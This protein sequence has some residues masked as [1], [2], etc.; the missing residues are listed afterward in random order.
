MLRRGRHRQDPP[1]LLGGRVLDHDVEH[2]A[3]ELRLGQRI[4]AFLL[5][6][7]LRRE[8]EQRPLE[9]VADAG[10]RDLVLLHRLE[11]RRL[12]LGRR[13]VDLVRQDDVREDRAV[14]E[15]DDALAGRAVLLDDLGAEDVGRH[16]VGR[17]LDAVELQVDALGERLDQQRLGEPG[18]AAQQAVAAGEERDQD[19]ADDALLADDR[20]GQLPLEPPG[21]LGDA[22][23]WRRIRRTRV[24]VYDDSFTARAPGHRR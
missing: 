14:D 16:Q 9:R 23:D 22:L 21:H 13:A 4:G 19:L 8:H 24:H 20:L 6:R 7:V 18:H 3:I 2:E 1:L 12:G 17:E 10:D 11:Q 5:D 15:P